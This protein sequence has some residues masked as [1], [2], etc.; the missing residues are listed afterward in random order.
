[1]IIE[2]KAN[3]YI[4]RVLNVQQSGDF[5]V[6]PN[7]VDWLVINQGDTGA[8]LNGIYLKPYP[9]GHPEL[10]GSTFSPDGKRD[11]FMMV[12]FTVSFD[13]P[14]GAMPWLQIVQKIYTNNYL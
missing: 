11:E 8:R 9:P 4:L 3:C 2:E 10:V 5:N 14:L 1:M 13:D 6:F 12:P 7:C